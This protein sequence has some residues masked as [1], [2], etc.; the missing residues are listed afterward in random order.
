MKDTS[1][2]TSFIFFILICV[3]LL[4][5]CMCRGIC[6]RQEGSQVLAIS[7]QSCQDWLQVLSQLCSPPAPPR[8]KPCSPSIHPTFH[9]VCW[10]QSFF[11]EYHCICRSLYWK[12]VVYVCGPNHNTTYI[13]PPPPVILICKKKK[14]R[15]QETR[16]LS[17]KIING[18]QSMGGKVPCRL[19]CCQLFLACCVS[20]SPLWSPWFWGV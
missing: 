6:G 4:I 18:R 1:T 8:L 9:S 16:K 19:V 17:K 13:L 12:G 5:M 10:E 11:I 15:I 7:S 20:L 3:D 14:K 2:Q